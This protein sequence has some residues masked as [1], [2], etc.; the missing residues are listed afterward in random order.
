ME[1]PW[2]LSPGERKVALER[3]AADESCEAIAGDYCVSHNTI[4]R[5]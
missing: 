5:L 2:S 3:R 1:R 4:S